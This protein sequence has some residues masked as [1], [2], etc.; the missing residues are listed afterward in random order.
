MRVWQLY[1]ILSGDV[2]HPVSV[3]QTQPEWCRFAAWYNEIDNLIDMQE[4][5]KLD[6]IL[7][8]N[9]VRLVLE[10]VDLQYFLHRND[11]VSGRISPGDECLTALEAFDRY[12]GQALEEALERGRYQVVNN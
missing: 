2:Q 1:S 11:L 3:A 7:P 8:D 12:G 10:R 6:A 9:F 5:A 4:R